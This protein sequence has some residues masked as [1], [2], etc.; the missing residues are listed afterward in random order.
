MKVDI[1]L[2]TKNP[3]QTILWGVIFPVLLIVFTLRDEQIHVFVFHIGWDYLALILLSIGTDII[4]Q[5]TCFSF[6]VPNHIMWF[7][8]L[9]FSIGL[10][11]KV[12]EN[13][14]FFGFCYWFQLV[15]IPFFRF[16]YSIV[17]VHFPMDIMSYF[18]MS[19][20]IFYVRIVQL[21]T[22]WSVESVFLFAQS[23]YWV[24]SGLNNICLMVSTW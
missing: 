12:S 9:Y 20:F 2:K 4:N 14:S 23:I 18:I 17:C 3:N 15:L 24:W 19:V 7:I 11:S 16:Q 10:D 1:L 22:K 5:K 8:A 6:I 13:G 21:D